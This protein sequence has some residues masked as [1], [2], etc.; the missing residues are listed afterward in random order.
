MIAGSDEGSP[1]VHVYWGGGNG[2]FEEA[3]DSPFRFA[4]GAKNIA[5][6]DFDGDG[7]AD[8]AVTCYQSRDVLLLVGGSG[9]LRSVTV[10]GGEHPWG[11]VAIDLN[12]DESDDLGV[13]DEANAVITVY[14]S[15]SD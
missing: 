10:H 9:A 1:L 3:D 2:G 5:V 7:V 12:G 11:L 15:Q 13:A 14:V 6:G 8:A 4:P